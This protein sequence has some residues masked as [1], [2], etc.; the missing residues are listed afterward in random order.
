MPTTHADY[1]AKY[2]PWALVMGGSQGLG[3]A[4]ASQ[5]VRR[6]L[7][8]VIC[9]RRADQLDAAAR[10]LRESHGAEVRT[11]TVDAA[12]ADAAEQV[13]TAVSDL[14][15]GFLVYNCAAEPGGLFLESTEQEQI[16]NIAVNCTTPTL[17]IQRLARPMAARGRGGIV[18]CS[19]L[20]AMQGIYNR[21]IYG[22]GKAYE[23]LLGEGLW[24]ELSQHGVGA[25]SFMIGSTYTP[26]F[27][28]DQQ[29]RNTIFANSRT[30][31]GLAQ[32]TQVPQAPEEAA[33]SLFMQIDQGWK[34]LIFANPLDEA[35]YRQST[36][37]DRESAITRMREMFL[38]GY[39]SLE[40]EA[41]GSSA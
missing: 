31:E 8:V 4:I 40:G 23:M 37:A 36:V 17:L 26:N 16:E 9:G 21:V 25:A 20:A 22:A 33:A 19:S 27:I 24:A 34:P 14:E 41:A 38:S 5:L 13:C 1:A 10:Q 18:V 7:G 12:S 30:P 35:R 2:G 39:R 3:L 11:V 15:V 29:A 28:H 6:S 32:G